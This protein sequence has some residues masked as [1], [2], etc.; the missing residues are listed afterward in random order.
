MLPWLTFVHIAAF[1]QLLQIIGFVQ[2]AA[3]N[4]KKTTNTEI[5]ERSIYSSK[6]GIQ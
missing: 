4:T 3:T 1:K 5:Q 2:A 6:L